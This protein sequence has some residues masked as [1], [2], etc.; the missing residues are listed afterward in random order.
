MFLIFLI[1]SFDLDRIR[2]FN[3]RGTLRNRMQITTQDTPRSWC[4]VSMLHHCY[5][6]SQDICRVNGM[7]CILLISEH[8]NTSIYIYGIKR[9]LVKSRVYLRVQLVALY[10]GNSR[11]FHAHVYK[12][13]C[14]NLRKKIYK[15]IYVIQFYID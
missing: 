2:I 12:R 4:I 7:G 1:N 15:Y 13:Q 3:A 11:P 14:Y 10:K 5:H 9:L 6:F 8:Y